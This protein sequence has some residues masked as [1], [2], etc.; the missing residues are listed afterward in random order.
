LTGEDPANFYDAFY[1]KFDWQR[2]ATV[3][4]G[5]AAILDK[6]TAHRL[7]DRYPTAQQVLQDLSR[8][9][10]AQTDWT[11]T[12]AQQW[13]AVAEPAS[14]VQTVGSLKTLVVA[15]LGTAVAAPI[16]TPTI[17]PV[18]LKPDTSLVAPQRRPLGWLWRGMVG[19]VRSLMIL[20]LLV[21]TGV[22][23]WA[24]VR[25][26]LQSQSVNLPSG[27]TVST[28]PTESYSASEQQRKAQ[29]IERLNRSQ[30]SSN[31]FYR[32]AN[33]AY[34]LQYPDQR[35]RLLGNGPED[36]PLRRNWDQVAVQV[37]EQIEPLS[38]ATQA[39]LG[40]YTVRDRLQWQTQLNA[41][42]VDSRSFFQ[43]A[44]STLT[45]ALPMYRG[46]DLRNTAA[47]QLL[48]GIVADRVQ[49]LKA[50]QNT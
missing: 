10:H 5:F 39:R 42:R 23:G 28:Q 27:G 45:G 43:E 36:E 41:A 31:F 20:L 24:A 40:R 21:G 22:L 14:A 47:R 34:Y 37:L 50:N 2:K 49:R 35:G 8:L 1:L 13:S 9:G 6:L 12:P 38:P 18:S 4:A 46:V 15:P 29:L 25:G 33:E 3:S 17:Q 44:E 48:D 19:L 7:S 30:V 11:V 32:L 26:W 16:S